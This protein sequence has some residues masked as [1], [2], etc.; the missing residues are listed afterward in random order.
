VILVCFWLYLMAVFDCNSC[1][2]KH[3]RPVGKNCTARLAAMAQTSQQSNQVPITDAVDQ[4]P[5]PPLSEAQASGSN[6]PSVTT[7]Q[8]PLL[9]Q[10]SLNNALVED[11]PLDESGHSN[12]GRSN[13][14]VEMLMELRAINRNI[15]F[16]IR[17]QF[18][19]KERW[20]SVEQFIKVS[21][22]L[23]ARVNTSIGLSVQPSVINS[24]NVIYCTSQAGPTY[25]SAGSRQIETRPTGLTSIPTHSALR[26]PVQAMPIPAIPT[27]A[28]LRNNQRWTAEV[29]SHY[30][31]LEENQIGNI[32][33]NKKSRRLL[34]AGGESS[35]HVHIDWPHDYVLSGPDK[36]RIYY[37][38]LNLEQW[39]YCY[40]CI[41]EN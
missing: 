28:E 39:A 30:N 9:A 41:L 31:A 22:S 19:E 29:Q 1:K 21:N 34:R 15:E 12:S 40:T 2:I 8:A 10:P 33:S 23:S 35:R 32:S 11:D 6:V 26:A 4:Q 17:N 14:E 3:P 38:D 20:N 36:D 7:S 24:N 16:M 13:T 27:I 18:E 5:Q 25:S 37:K